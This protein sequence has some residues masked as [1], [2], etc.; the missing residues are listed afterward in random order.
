MYFWESW[1]NKSEIEKRAIESIAEAIKVLF[2]F[3]PRNKIF[4]IYIKGSFVRREMTEKSDVDI[5]PITLDNITLSIIDQ[6]QKEK[7]KI[8]RPAELLPHSL[9]EFELGEKYLKSEG[10]KANVDSFLRDLSSYQLIFGEPIDIS[11]YKIRTDFEFLRDHIQAFRTIFIPLYLEGKFGFSDLIKQVFF[12]VQKVERV[13]GKEPPSNWKELAT[14]VDDDTHIIYECLKFR[15][16]S[17]K[18]PKAREEFIRR[19]NWYLDSLSK[20]Y[21]SYNLGCSSL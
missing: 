5:V 18:D 10:P 17:V 14:F 4:A 6:L 9:E 8:Y 3:V 21:L 16:V 13:K 12:L 1:K 19:L 15:E 2:E 11:K 7:G 20:K